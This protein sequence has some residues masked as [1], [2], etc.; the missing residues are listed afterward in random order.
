VCQACHRARA[1]LHAPAARL[2]RRLGTGDSA[3]FQREFAAGARGDHTGAAGRL[4]D[5]IPNRGASALANAQPVTAPDAR[6]AKRLRVEAAPRHLDPVARDLLDRQAAC[7]DDRR[8][9]D[10][11]TRAATARQNRVAPLG[12]PAEVFG[13][14]GGRRP[15]G[16]FRKR[17][18]PRPVADTR[19][20]P[21]KVHAGQ[22]G[23]GPVQLEGRLGTVAVEGDVGEQ[24]AALR[25]SEHRA[26]SNTAGAGAVDLDDAGQNLRLGVLPRRHGDDMRRPFDGE[27]RPNRRERPLW[28]AIRPGGD[29]RGVHVEGTRRRCAPITGA[30]RG[31]DTDAGPP[32]QT[33]RTD[34]DGHTPRSVRRLHLTVPAGPRLEARFPGKSEC[35]RAAVRRRRRGTDICE[36]GHF[37]ALGRHT[38]APAVRARRPGH[39]ATHFQGVFALAAWG[40]RRGLASEAFG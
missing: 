4:D 21:R 19:P 28:R 36:L 8:C 3:P 22:G 15:D 35:R 9:L 40:R 26:E 29:R 33:G 16:D 13:A 2:R 30:A 38:A 25:G 7:G 32:T 11:Q 39:T 27:R 17:R 37:G 1:H 12:R 34:L 20:A 23:L 31:V 5:D 18:L 10:S 6:E 24:D 14:P